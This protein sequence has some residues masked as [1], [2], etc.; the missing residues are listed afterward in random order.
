MFV[1]VFA[2]Y[3]LVDFPKLKQGL[4]SLAPVAYQEIVVARVS[5]VDRAISSFVRGQLLIAIILA[6]IN[7]IGLMILDV[8][9]GLGIGLIAGLANMIPYMALVVGLIPALALAWAEHQELVRLLG[10]VAVFGGAQALEGMVLSPRILGRS[11]N[12]H[13]VWVLLA[14]IAGGSLFGF[15]GMLAAVP[16]AASIQVFVGHWLKAYRKSAVYQSA[17]P[18]VAPVDKTNDAVNAG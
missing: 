3:L 14:I 7:A 18:T 10:V 6:A 9:F 15:V 2:F 16:V 5:E 1:P 17:P 8:P 12:L 11:V 13:P 4:L